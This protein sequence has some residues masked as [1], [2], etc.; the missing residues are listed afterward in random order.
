VGIFSSGSPLP[1][2][3]EATK[4]AESQLLSI[5]S[6][7]TTIVGDLETSGVVK[8]EGRIQGTVKTAAQILLA[9]GGVIEGNLVA[10]E[11]ILGGEV[12][13]AVQAEERVEVQATA[14]INGDIT[15]R[16]IV[17]VEGGQVNGIVSTGE[18]AESLQVQVK[19]DSA[20]MSGAGLNSHN[21]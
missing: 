20:Q 4:R 15:T 1:K 2:S 6:T 19:Q 11:A 16:R 13:G 5:I 21:S 3:A 17:I 12:Y 9:K 14:I 10:R 18:P 7:G 8:I